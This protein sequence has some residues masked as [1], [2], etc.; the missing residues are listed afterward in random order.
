MLSASL[1]KTFLS[2]GYSSRGAISGTRKSLMGPTKSIDPTTYHTMNDTVG[3][4][5]S[6]IIYVV[7]LRQF[8]TIIYY[9]SNR[10]CVSILV[11]RERHTKLTPAFI[12]ITLT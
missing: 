4:R 5:E 1:N 12:D 10:Q 8:S 2:P 3:H 6:S 9:E 7:S 11:Y